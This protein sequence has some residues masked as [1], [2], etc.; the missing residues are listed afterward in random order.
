MALDFL[1]DREKIKELLQTHEYG[2]LPAA[3]QR[4]W[5]EACLSSDADKVFC[6]GKAP[7]ERFI[8]HAETESGKVVFPFSVCLP[9]GEGKKK[10]V[11]VLSFD[12]EIPNKYLPAEE[13][14][15][16]GWGFACLHYESVSPDTPVLDEN[17]R[18]LGFGESGKVGKLM[19]WAWAAMRVADCLL[20]REDIDGDNL[21]IA[22]HSRLGKT[23]LLAG[24]FDERFAFVHSNCSGVAGAA[25]YSSHNHECEDIKILAEIRPYWF[26]DE[27]RTY[28]GKEKELPFDQHYL[29]GLI[30]PRCVSIGSAQDDPRANPKGELDGARVASIAWKA[31]EKKGLIAPEK[32][33]VG[34]NYHSGSVGY[35]MRK[36]LHYFSR[37]DWNRALDFF[38]NKL[39]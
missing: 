1:R 11:L 33:E 29:I 23:A 26:A 2:F 3:P 34:V 32:I 19:I 16:R 17:A 12:K 14:I 10:V 27:Y 36:G 13:I 18:A 21:A 22:G 5:A 31:Y 9:K 25:L 24:A 35:Y 6:A 20:L 37:E 4:V 39:N 8:L 38:E 7:I 28:I 30:A 15:D